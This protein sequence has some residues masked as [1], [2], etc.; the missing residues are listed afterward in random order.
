MEIEGKNRHFQIKKNE[1]DEKWWESYECNELNEDWRLLIEI[2]HA[3]KIYLAN[4]KL[5]CRRGGGNQLGELKGNNKSD[6]NKPGKWRK[7]FHFIQQ[8]LGSFILRYIFFLL[9]FYISLHLYL[10]CTFIIHSAIAYL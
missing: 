10:P 2:V 3:F 8:F 7:K 9:L 6:G 5:K 4:N 1:R